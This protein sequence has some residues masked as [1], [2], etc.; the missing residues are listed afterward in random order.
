MPK[1]LVSVSQQNYRR[2]DGTDDTPPGGGSVGALLAANNLSDVASVATAL[3]NLGL[4]G[5]TTATFTYGS[6]GAVPSSGTYTAG[7]FVID[8]NGIP[9][10]CTVSGSPGTWRRAYAQPYDFYVDDYGA[11][12]NATECLVTTV[13]GSHNIT[14]ST[15]VF[16]STAVD[17]GKDIM[18]CGAGGAIPGGP[19]I[20][21]IATITD[22]THAVLTNAIAAGG[23][24]SG[25]AC[26]FASSDQTA[27]DNCYTAAQTY[28][29]AHGYFARVIYSDKKYSVSTTLF[30]SVAGSD[31]ATLS[32]NAQIRLP[33]G[34]DL[35]GESGK[36]EIHSLGP[37]AGGQCRFWTAVSEDAPGTVIFS[38]SSGP[39]SADGTYGQ[40]AIMQM[41]IGGAGISNDTGFF[42]VKAVV[43]GITF[44]QPGWSN[45][46]GLD[47]YTAC[48]H[49]ISVTSS[50]FA[51]STDEGGGVNPYIDW[52]T[53]SFWI[54]N[55][56]GAG[57]RLSNA[58]NN[59]Q[60][61]SDICVQGLNTGIITG[62]D[63][64]TLKRLST[65][66]TDVVIKM[67]LGGNTQHEIE[68]R[69]SPENYNT[70]I[71]VTGGSPTASRVMCHLT[72][73]SE[74]TSS[75]IAGDD[76]TDA[77][78]QLYGDL[79]WS[80]FS[81]DAGGLADIIVPTVSGAANLR[82]HNVQLT[83][84]VYD[85]HAYGYTL[86]TAFQNPWF[87]AMWLSIAGG[88]V[89]GIT[90]GPTSAAATTTVPTAAYPGFVLPSGWW[91]NIAGS[92]KPTTF[93]AVP[94]LP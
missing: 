45:S 24:G 5:A 6:S 7:Q 80:D 75:T 25:L 85:A 52:F 16:T 76:V 74:Q 70:G 84:Q 82:I 54:D 29:M 39:N 17:G 46:V 77:N 63:H 14:A 40:Q 22:S 28:A 83:Q 62:A 26:V 53:Q 34:T 87:G 36:F 19:D 64:V 94:V 42:N 8:Q 13:A 48:E 81:R 92:G 31:G 59:D 50:V 71:L 32:Y 10:V 55:K 21:T 72:W 47:L 43:R 23:S 1:N 79:W 93:L 41:P 61:E 58:Q 65:A 27:I 78:N 37:T 86:G 67:N 44:V 90:I 30:Q 60:C 15:A 4:V 35:T 66:A 49:D 3:A 38:F 20:N 56:I 89:S 33:V 69:V 88:T 73:D 18:T 9:R 57:V 68:G 2:A 91:I 11:P 51:P 12:A